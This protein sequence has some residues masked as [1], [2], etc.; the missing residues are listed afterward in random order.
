MRSLIASSAISFAAFCLF[1]AAPAHA[2]ILYARP[3]GDPMSGAYRWGD[4]IVLDPIPFKSAIDIAKAANGSRAL[5][6]RLLHQVGAQETVY[7]VNLSSFQSALRWQGS[8]DKRLLIR[9]QIEASEE[10]PRPL[11]WVVGQS[12]GQTVCELDG[13]DVCALP[14]Q[15]SPTGQREARQDLLH[16]LA[17]E[18]ERPDVVKEHSTSLDN[19]LRLHCFLL[20]ESAFVD[21]ADMGFRD[22]WFSAVASYASSNITLRNSVI[23]GSTWAFLAVGKKAAPETAYSFEVTGNVWK[24]SPATYRSGKLSCD[25]H[26]DWDCPVSIWSDVPWGVVHHHFWRPLNGALFMARD[27]LGNVRILD[28][29]IFDAYNGIRTTLSDQCL[30]TVACIER[31]SLGFEIARNTFENI[32]DNPVE[33]E[34]HMAF[35]VVKHNTFINAHAVISTDGVSGHDLLVFGNL[36][37]MNSIPGSNCHE[38][39]WVGSRQFVARRGGGEWSTEAAEGDDAS[40]SSHRMGTAIKLGGDDANPSHPLLKRIFFFNNSL[41]TRSPL[42]RGS[43]APPITSYN[44]AVEF[45]G[46]GTL[47]PVSCRQH[48]TPDP[49]CVGKAFW[50]Q[51]GEALFADCFPVRDRKGD[52]V[53]HRMRFNAYNRALEPRLDGVDTDR[54]PAPVAFVGSGTGRSAAVA[55]ERMFA[56]DAASPLAS[57]GCRLTYASDDLRCEG[58]GALVGALLPTGERFD[59]KIPFRFPFT[60]VLRQAP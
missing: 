3:D 7:S 23:H 33:P 1:A 18:L 9:G 52:A 34:D 32:R 40:C 22:C 20:W 58:S 8:E 44:N 36:F 37:V 25:I 38:E 59:L 41:R 56:I 55:A 39:G 24:Q 12:L 16:Q 47:G 15:Q 6:I 5:E 48:P 14:S 45:T 17:D 53:P 10:G 50:T 51:D 57:S 11:T 54:V 35:W 2:D 43:P 46:C 27:I 29:Q 4:E 42:F 26:N 13:N 28:N 31:T 19:H 49:S 60:E 21:V 30:R